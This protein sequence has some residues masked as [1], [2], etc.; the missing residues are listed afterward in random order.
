M[1]QV[2]II[3]HELNGKLVVLNRITFERKDLP[4]TK[5]GVK[6]CF[7]DGSCKGLSKIKILNNFLK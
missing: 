2:N 5:C 3:H 7:C 4:K 1:S 6:N